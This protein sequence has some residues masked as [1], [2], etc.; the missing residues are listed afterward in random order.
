MTETETKVRWYRNDR[1]WTTRDG[2]TLALEDMTPEHRANLR[3]LMLHPRV[4]VD[5]K[6]WMGMELSVSHSEYDGDAIL[7]DLMRMIHELDETPAVDVM[8]GTPLYK[9]L[10]ELDG[11]DPATD[12]PVRRSDWEGR[13]VQHRRHKRI[14]TVVGD[15]GATN[16]DVRVRYDDGTRDAWVQRSSLNLIDLR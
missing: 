12:L 2:R 5:V 16:L 11:L 4:A 14:G 8:R 10:S 3:R 13:R 1:T 6:F 9:R 15:A 7:D